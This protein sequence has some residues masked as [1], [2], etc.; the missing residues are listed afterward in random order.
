MRDF[1]DD[2]VQLRILRASHCPT[3]LV[4]GMKIAIYGIT[5]DDLQK[6]EHTQEVLVTM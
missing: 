4:Y 5:Q 1:T 3:H 2:H 6:Q